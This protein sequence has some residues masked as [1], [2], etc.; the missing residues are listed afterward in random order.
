M[1][2]NRD[3]FLSVSAAL[4]TAQRT[5][6]LY[7]PGH[8][9]IRD[10]LEECHLRLRELL[11]RERQVGFVLAGE[12]FVA[13]DLQI[14]IE[15][16]VLEDF[17]D[18]L[19]RAGA[20][21][22][23]FSD[24]LR[25]WELQAFLRFLAD[26]DE[27]V[28]A[29]GGIEAA[30]E[31]ADVEHVLARP[32]AMESSDEP[33][34]DLLVR[35]WEVYSRG[36]QSVRN[37]RRGY[38]SKGTLEHLDELKSFAHDLVDVAMQQTRPLLALQALKVHDEYS[39]THSINVAT[40]SLAIARGL[41]LPRYHLGDLTM[42]ALL[43]DLGKERVPGRILRK[44]GRLDDE[45]W[46]EMERHTLEGAK[47]LA[48]TD[49]VGD[50]ASVVAYEH[51]LDRGPE[52]PGGGPH[53][54]HIASDMVKLADVYDALRS[55]RPYRSGV[56][57]DRA[58]RIMEEETETGQKFDPDLFEG[59]RR[60]LGYYPPGT[61]VRLTDGAVALSVRTDP[62]DPSTPQL[63][64]VRNPDGS[65]VQPPERLNPADGDDRCPIA[66]A[67]DPDDLDL[68]PFDYL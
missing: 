39:F 54:P 15:G 67:V 11:Q 33:T 64:V 19:R 43:H 49:G 48:L 34:P 1:F 27:E 17:A 68:D 62:E 4:L 61:C 50:L 35:A 9:H 51:H 3:E 44:A 18:A 23:I 29:R 25:Q 42:A 2:R 21:K 60:M 16:E 53:R 65:P 59:F 58:L 31:E 26:E 41:N 37:L 6:S 30:L 45:E 47:M 5:L 13:G 7:P 56:Q 57:A 36:L 46:A 8:P 52:G 38:R 24:G 12:E 63:L 22:I 55:D 66:E 40:L 20:G 28:E 32:L 10:A 14:E